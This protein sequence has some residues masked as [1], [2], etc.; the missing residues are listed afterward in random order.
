MDRAP[1]PVGVS[2]YCVAYICLG[3]ETMWPFDA[4]RQALGLGYDPA[5]SLPACLS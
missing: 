2:G 5:S 4:A 1:S 3:R